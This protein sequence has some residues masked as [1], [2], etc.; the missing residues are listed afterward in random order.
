MHSV[1]IGASAG[2][3]ALVRMLAWDDGNF[4]F[5]AM[6]E[7]VSF[8]TQ[9]SMPIEAGLLEAARF[10]D[11]NRRDAHAALPREAGLRVEHQTVDVEDPSLSKIE[12]SILD[13]AGLG[14]TVARLI[15]TIQEPDRLVEDCILDL[16]E[17]GAIRFE[18]SR[19]S[20]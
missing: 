14:M 5:H 15:D 12:Q 7:P 20:G 6:T 2:I 1:Q 19:D 16:V 18:G 17:R 9:W 13:L 8:A 11:E 3:K 10:L 4:E